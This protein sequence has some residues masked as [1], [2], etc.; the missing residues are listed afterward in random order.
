MASPTF[1]IEKAALLAQGFEIEEDFI[2]A[3]NPREAVEK[4]GSNFLYVA[5][6]LGKSD[7]GYAAAVAVQALGK[8]L[9]GAEAGQLSK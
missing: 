1:L 9:L 2:D 5:D 6:E 4:Y 8:T 7:A 3:A